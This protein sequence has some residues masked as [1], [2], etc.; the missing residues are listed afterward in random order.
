MV[1]DN[2]YFDYLIQKSPPQGICT[3]SENQCL[4]NDQNFEKNFPGNI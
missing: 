1:L 3:P 4:R 2:Q